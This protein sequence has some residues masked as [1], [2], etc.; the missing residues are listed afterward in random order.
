[1]RIVHVV[2]YSMPQMGYQEFLLPKFNAINGDDVYIIT[3]DRYF[4]VPNYDETWKTLLGPRI[5]GPGESLISNVNIIRLET[6]FEMKGRPWIKGLNEN[7]NRLKP[8]I[9]FVHGTGSLSAYRIA[10][11]HLNHKPIILYDNH[12]IFD[13]IQKGF[14]QDIYYWFHKMIFSKLIS[15]RAKYIYGVTEETCQYL[16]DIEGFP[17]H[18]VKHLPLSVDH[19]HFCPKN[20]RRKECKPTVVVQTGKFNLDKKPNWTARVCLDLLREGE[21][22]TLRLVGSGDNSILQKIKTDFRNAGYIDKLSIEPMVPYQQLPKIFQESDIAI[23]PDGTSLSAL[24]AAS[25]GCSVIMANLPASIY[26]EKTGIGCTYERGN[27]EDLKKKLLTLILE[28]DH[29]SIRVERTREIIKKYYSYSKVANQML[30]DI[31]AL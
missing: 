4:P 31:D 5:C 23:Y 25:S 15:R 21:N 11:G 19:Y 7:L 2:D 24:E 22:I 17:S 14:F 6:S 27:I 12:M 26:R 10:I 3:S 16:I 1:M 13:I 8:D 9:V 20:K 29:A 18:K 30:D 28:R